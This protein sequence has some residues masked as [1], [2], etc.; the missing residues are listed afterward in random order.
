LDN[1]G[2]INNIDLLARHFNSRWAK[3]FGLPK[4]GDAECLLEA[5]VD[6]QTC[7]PQDITN[8]VEFDQAADSIENEFSAPDSEPN[9]S[10]KQTTQPKHS[11]KQQIYRQ[12]MTVAERVAGFVSNSTEM[13]AAVICA[14]EHMETELHAG[15]APAVPTKIVLGPAFRDATALANDGQNNSVQE[16]AC[17]P[18]HTP[19]RHQTKRIKNCGLIE[20]R[21]QK[22]SGRTKLPAAK[23]QQTGSRLIQG[24][25]SVCKLLEC[26][27]KGPHCPKMSSFGTY[28]PPGSYTFVLNHEPTSTYVAEL[29]ECCDNSFDSE[30]QHIIIRQ[31]CKDQSGHKVCSIG[32]VDKVLAWT[33]HQFLY[34]FSALRCWL[35]LKP[36][37]KHLYIRHGVFNEG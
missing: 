26:P 2:A 30:W 22:L 37:K 3:R 12:V 31:I 28:I 1:I 21:K 27:K 9:L 7:C 16:T 25:C 4:F 24:Q 36:A 35:E 8:S 29:S 17:Y 20:T 33:G 14:L 6:I 34:S 13:A 19:G 11:K 5:P 23:K 15:R 18:T 10:A 32:T